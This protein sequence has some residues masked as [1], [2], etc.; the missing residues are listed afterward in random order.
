M[1]NQ[2]YEHETCTLGQNAAKHTTSVRA[3]SQKKEGTH[4][5]FSGSKLMLYVSSGQ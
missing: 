2:T 5:K 3:I 1:E 4:Y